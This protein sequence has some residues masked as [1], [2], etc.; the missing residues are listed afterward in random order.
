MLQRIQRI[1]LFISL[2]LVSIFA[3]SGNAVAQEEFFFGS[4]FVCILI[5]VIIPL[6]IA[7]LLG[8]WIYRDANS[9]GMNGT[10]WAVLV[11]VL[12]IAMGAFGIVVVIIILIIY[13]VLRNDHPVL[14]PGYYPPPGYGYGY[15][16]PPPPP[17]YGYPPPPPGYGYP[18]PPP[19]PGYS[20]PPSRPR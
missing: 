5:L 10:L 13:L 11:I 7:I 6:I 3:L 14:P 18:P 9:R 1:L 17:G 4:F 15:G 12:P 2:I 19:P 20:Y 8:I 16:Y